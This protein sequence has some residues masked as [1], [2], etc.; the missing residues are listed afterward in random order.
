MCFESAHCIQLAGDGRIP[1]CCL[2][3]S[4]SWDD[5]RR[6]SDAFF[7]LGSTGILNRGLASVQYWMEQCSWHANFDAMAKDLGQA[8][9]IS[10][11]CRSWIGDGSAWKARPQPDQGS[12]LEF[13]TQSTDQVLLQ[14][15]ERGHVLRCVC[16]SRCCMPD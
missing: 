13:G 1:D 9:S 8:A 10:C 2:H 7:L 16:C 4:F 15:T 12:K 5:S 14:R 6:A 3:S 11:K